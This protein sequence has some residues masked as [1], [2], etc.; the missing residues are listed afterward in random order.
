MKKRSNAENRVPEILENYYQVVIDEGFEGASIG[1]VAKHMDIHPSLIIHYFKSKENLIVELVN[2]IVEKYNASHFLE[3][4][5]IQ[6]LEE[7]FSKMMNVLF[8]FEWSR[9]VHPQVCFAFY[10][11][12]FRVSAIKERYQKLFLDFRD[13]LTNEFRFYK[14]AGIINVAD[15]VKAADMV[16]I[17]IEGLEFHAG[18]L[19]KEE[20]F[21]VFAD[22]SKQVAIRLLKKT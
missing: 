20:S 18:F 12:S 6:N 22:Y 2:L 1:K 10:Y 11:L 15:P 17:L 8:S 3:L 16:V 19:K 9:T 5:H 21:E 14:K 4:D 7:R 13:Y